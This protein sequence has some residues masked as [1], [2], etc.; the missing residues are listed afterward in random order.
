[1]TR[2]VARS[3]PEAPGLGIELDEEK[4][5][6]YGEKF[7]EITSRGIAVKAIREKGFFTALRLARKRRSR[8]PAAPGSL[9]PGKSE[10]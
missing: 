10:E 1:M 5:S 8:A 6:R 4:L 7:F 2:E 3:V 9:D